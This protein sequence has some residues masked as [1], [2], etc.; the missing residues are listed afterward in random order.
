MSNESRRLAKLR[1]LSARRH[2][3]I[4][5]PVIDEND[6]TA[7]FDVLY[8][9]A[10]ELHEALEPKKPGRPGSTYLPPMPPRNRAEGTE[11]IK[12]KL[13]QAARA[14]G[15]QRA[16]R[17]RDKRLELLGPI[18]D[19]ANRM[20]PTLREPFTTVEFMPQHHRASSRPRTARTS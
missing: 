17:N 7:I 18:V 2:A 11:W 8:A 12:W 14:A 15:G 1:R 9:D 16:P 20:L 13:K 19:E 3:I 4:T 5:N 10:V 6:P